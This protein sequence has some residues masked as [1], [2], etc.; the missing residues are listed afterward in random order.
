MLRQTSNSHVISAW[1]SFFWLLNHHR[2]EAHPQ[3]GPRLRSLASKLTTVV[4]QHC[5]GTKNRYLLSNIATGRKFHNLSTFSHLAVM[6]T[7]SRKWSTAWW[8]NPRRT[9][10]IYVMIASQLTSPFFFRVGLM[11]HIQICADQA[12]QSLILIRSGRCN[13]TTTWLWIPTTSL[14]ALPAGQGVEG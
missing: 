4:E 2:R 3:V 13:P 6:C 14:P 7:S 12:V 8:D 9:F 1:K 10:P 11:I 5:L